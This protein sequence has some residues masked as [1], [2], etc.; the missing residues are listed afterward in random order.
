MLETGNSCTR[1]SPNPHPPPVC[2]PSCC[3]GHKNRSAESWVVNMLCHRSHRH[4][5]H[6]C[7]YVIRP[8]TGLNGQ[9]ALRPQPFRNV[10]NSKN[11]NPDGSE[12]FLSCLLLLFFCH[13]F[14][15]SSFEF[16]P[17]PP[18]SF[19]CIFFSFSSSFF[20]HPCL[21]LR[22]KLH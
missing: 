11:D 14:P 21:L 5:K 4:Y 10:N 7:C 19:Y 12:T 9:L 15:C 20:P 1:S 2:L 6:L 18:Q 22:K 16:V 8:Q 3:R 17:F 13:T